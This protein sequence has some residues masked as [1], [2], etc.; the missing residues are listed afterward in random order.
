[1]MKRK[2]LQTLKGALLCTA[3]LLLLG[4]T[5]YTIM[6]Q[7]GT[8]QGTVTDSSTGQP[9][10]GVRVMAHSAQGDQD[11]RGG[12]DHGGGH[13]GYRAVTG[14]DGSYVMDD[15]TAGDYY[16]GACAPGYIPSRTEAT[17][18]EGEATTVD[19]ALDPLTF[20]TV[21][22]T[23]TDADTGL[24]LEGAIVFA[25]PAFDEQPLSGLGGGFFKRHGHLYHGKGVK[26][27][28]YGG[29][30]TGEHPGCGLKGGHHGDALEGDHHGFG[31]NGGPH[32]GGH[33]G[34]RDITGEDGTYSLELPTGS[35][36]ITALMRGYVRASAEAEV[37]E[38]ETTTVDLALEPMTF[39]SMAGTVTDADTGE[40][41]AGAFV[42]LRRSGGSLLGGGGH[43]GGH[44]GIHAITGEDGTYLIEN[45]PVGDY[46]AM[47]RAMGYLPSDPVD[48]TILEDQ[49]TTQDFALYVRSGIYSS[50]SN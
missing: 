6:A 2:S 8:I 45:A 39:G 28:Y 22:G 9:L 11:G 50:L 30:L 7:T 44:H 1:M 48:V 19:F 29:G 4:L 15:V 20:G 35:W 21:S 17:V 13:H 3:V 32:G 34:F 37:I 27:C 41:V 33:H 16:V 42:V 14:V 25:R 31:R 36:V 18:N 23:V 26:G 12:G 24:P 38:G 46:R 49:T 10:E 5:P 47:A 43:G 40:P